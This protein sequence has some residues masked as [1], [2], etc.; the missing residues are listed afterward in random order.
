MKK[1]WI[2][3]LL[4]S[5][6]LFVIGLFIVLGSKADKPKKQHYTNKT[7]LVYYADKKE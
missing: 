4:I 2:I 1:E 3:A 6:A 5:L 7:D